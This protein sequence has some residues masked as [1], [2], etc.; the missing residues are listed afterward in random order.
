M[1][2]NK[3]TNKWAGKRTTK[4]KKLVKFSWIYQID[5]YV[6]YGFFLPIFTN[7][8]MFICQNVCRYMILFSVHFCCCC[9]CCCCNEVQ[10]RL[11][12]NAY[13]NRIIFDIIE[14]IRSTDNDVYAFDSVLVVIIFFNSFYIISQSTLSV[15]IYLTR[16]PNE[17]YFIY[18]LYYIPFDLLVQVVA[19]HSFI[20]LSCISNRQRKQQHQKTQ[21]DG[22][23]FEQKST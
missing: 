20:Y 6:A 3:Q 2:K 12:T 19:L 13:R 9:C 11:H 18:Q 15:F 21:H 1:T 8:Q 23:Q 16:R 7:G 14:C 4:K 5:T 17:I 22:H 10:W